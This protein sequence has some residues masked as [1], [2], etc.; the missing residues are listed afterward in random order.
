ML[1]YWIPLN[2]QKAVDCKRLD[3]ELEARLDFDTCQNRTSDNASE[4]LSSGISP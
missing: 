1:R 3:F 4:R 2:T